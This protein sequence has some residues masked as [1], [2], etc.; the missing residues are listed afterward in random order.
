M[1]ALTSIVLG[2]VGRQIDAWLPGVARRLTNWAAAHMGPRRARMR[3]EWSAFLDET[4]GGLHKLWVAAQFCKVGIQCSAHTR[5]QLALHTASQNVVR[6]ELSVLG[7]ALR[8][9]QNLQLFRLDRGAFA[10]VLAGRVQTLWFSN[11]RQLRASI[12]QVRLLSTRAQEPL[13]TS[14]LELAERCE[15]DLARGEK[16]SADLAPI[17]ERIR[18]L[19]PR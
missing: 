16:A 10:L 7:F 12:N 13:R 19:R 3:E 6:L 14:V 17:I 15:K 2:L 1:E 5:I 18:A 9:Y 8:A 11:L 4:P